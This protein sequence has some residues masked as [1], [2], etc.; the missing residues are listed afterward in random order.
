MKNEYTSVRE[1]VEVDATFLGIDSDGSLKRVMRECNTD[2]D[3]KRWLRKVESVLDDYRMVSERISEI[4]KLNDYEMKLLEDSYEESPYNHKLLVEAAC[5][6]VTLSHYADDV[7]WSGYESASYTHLDWPVW[8]RRIVFKDS[9][10]N[11]PDWYQIIVQSRIHWLR[12]I[13]IAMHRA[14]KHPFFHLA[15]SVLKRGMTVAEI[16][17]LGLLV[18]VGR[19][20]AE[21]ESYIHQFEVLAERIESCQELSSIYEDKESL[22]EKLES[23]LKTLNVPMRKGSTTEDLV[24]DLIRA[25]KD[26]EVIMVIEQHTEIRTAEW[27]CM[28][29]FHEELQSA[30][31]YKSSYSNFH[32]QLKK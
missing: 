13:R 2:S 7:D 23:K 8:M 4:V 29:S 28:K 11:T 21:C 18:E 30:K 3:V 32:K 17:L 1:R 9:S 20:I 26:T 5:S 22:S 19:R 10:A 12:S 25:T 27:G 24:R 16:S 31:I 15:I 6:K 14:M